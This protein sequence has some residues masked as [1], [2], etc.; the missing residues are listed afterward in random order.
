MAT[1]PSLNQG[2]EKQPERQTLR[3]TGTDD[4][5]TML[6]AG[7]NRG[8]TGGKSVPFG[9]VACHHELKDGTSIK[10]AP[11]AESPHESSIAP[12]RDRTCDLRFRKQF[13]VAAEKLMKPS[14]YLIL[15]RTMPFARLRQ[16]L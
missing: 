15:L 5:S 16:A 13:F 14:N 6:H 8:K 12:D 4:I 9:A 10:P 7:K 11:D 3:A 2:N 1:L